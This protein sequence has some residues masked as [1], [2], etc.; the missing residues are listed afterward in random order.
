M[1]P[2]CHLHLIGKRRGI[3]GLPKCFYYTTL[4][5][6]DTAVLKMNYSDDYDPYGFIY[7]TSINL[8]T[9]DDFVNAKR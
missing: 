3:L 4:N 9:S 5:V 2:D 6:N 8:Y 1:T 7:R